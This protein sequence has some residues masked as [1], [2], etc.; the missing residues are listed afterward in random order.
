[1]SVATGSTTVVL[2][3][4]V[5]S[6]DNGVA[7]TATAMAMMRACFKVAMVKLLPSANYTRELGLEDGAL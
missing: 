2:V 6:A 3:V 1:M 5:A 4:V 7:P